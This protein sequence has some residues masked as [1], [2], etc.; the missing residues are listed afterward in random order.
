VST[1]SRFT[2]LVR[3]GDIRTGPARDHTVKVDV[4]GLKA[5]TTYY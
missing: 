4:T 2:S 5:D 1:D 3:S